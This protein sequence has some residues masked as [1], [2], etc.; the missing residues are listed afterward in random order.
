MGLPGPKGERGPEGSEGPPGPVGPKGDRGE[1]G[2][3]GPAGTAGARGGQGDVGPPGPVGPRGEK[4]P[5]GAVGAMGPTGPRGPQGEPGPAG[6]MGPSGPP[7]TVV[8][9]EPEVRAVEITQSGPTTSGSDVKADAKKDVRKVEKQTAEIE[10][11][12]LGSEGEPKADVTEVKG[13]SKTVI[14][15]LEGDSDSE[16]QTREVGRVAQK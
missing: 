5:Q 7:G 10:E 1:L 11:K 15:G 3:L 8:M 13:K 16:T 6:P 4:G 9:T 2:P 14:A 12:S